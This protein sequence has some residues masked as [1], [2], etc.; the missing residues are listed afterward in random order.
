M[1][2][3][4]AMEQI[5]SKEN[6]CPILGHPDYSLP[7]CRECRDGA[8]P[9]YKDCLTMIVANL[10]LQ[11]SSSPNTRKERSEQHPLET[12]DEKSKTKTQS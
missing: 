8:D 5:I 10:N 11:K 9:K 7:E 12:K 3:F 4:D 1:E 6:E 2:Y